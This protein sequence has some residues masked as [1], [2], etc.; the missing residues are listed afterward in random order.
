[1]ENIIQI[2]VEIECDIFTAFKMFTVN[3]YL[4]AWLTEKAEVEPDVGGKYELF[5]EPENR[6]NNSTIGCKITGIEENKF[7]AF[8]WKGPI[9]FKSFMNIADPLT[10]VIVFFSSDSNDQNK[11]IIYLFHTGWRKDEDWQ[12]AR[13]F[14][15]KAWLKALQELKEKIKN[16]AIP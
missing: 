15:D 12:E 3:N 1:M 6:E 7:I 8:D 9:Q 13:N 4:E 16:K 14:F 5:W 10:H 11:T 2:E